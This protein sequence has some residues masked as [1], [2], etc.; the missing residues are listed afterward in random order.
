MLR[1][2]VGCVLGAAGGM[3]L[4]AVLLTSSRE[5]ETTTSFPSVWHGGT[6]TNDDPQWTWTDS[7]ST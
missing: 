3:Y 5:D 4:L 7:T 6:F 2:L 1:F